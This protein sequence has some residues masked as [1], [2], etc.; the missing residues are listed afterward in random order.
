MKVRVI[1]LYV[2]GERRPRAQLEAVPGETGELELDAWDN[3]T[4][5]RRLQLRARLTVAAGTTRRD[6]LPPI[7]DVVVLRITRKGML[8]QG[9]QKVTYARTVVGFLQQWWC[10]PVGAE[11][12]EQAAEEPARKTSRLHG[13]KVS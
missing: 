8:L 7:Y 1:E 13:V 2:V 4:P 6:A 10:E 9:V 3:Q 11:P 12:A 5:D